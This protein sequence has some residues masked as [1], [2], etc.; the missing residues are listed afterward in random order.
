MIVDK[1][2]KISFYEAVPGLKKAVSFIKSHDLNS[3]DPGRTEIDGSDLYVNVDFVEEKEKDSAR[4]EAHEIYADLQI[5]LEGDELMG[6]FPEAE[7]GDPAESLP[8]NDICFY[9]ID[10]SEIMWLNIRQGMFAVFFPGDAHAP[11][12]RSGEKDRTKKAVFKIK[13]PDTGL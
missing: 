1:L 10:H 13:I 11:G 6:Y 9:D 7:L 3:L 5:M 2:E 12:V 8:Q 4:Y